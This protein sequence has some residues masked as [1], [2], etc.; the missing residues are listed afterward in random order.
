MQVVQGRDEDLLEYQKPLA[1]LVLSFDELVDD[2]DAEPATK[3]RNNNQKTR[4][5][6]FEHGLRV[7]P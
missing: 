1:K 7:L 5:K 3:E 6:E 2:V 4:V